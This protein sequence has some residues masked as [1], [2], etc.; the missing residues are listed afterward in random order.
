M[1][2]GH[3]DGEGDAVACGLLCDTCRRC[4]LHKRRV[5]GHGGVTAGGITAC[6]GGR[7]AEVRAEGERRR[8]IV[9]STCGERSGTE[10]VLVAHHPF[11]IDVVGKEGERER[12]KEKEKQ[13]EEVLR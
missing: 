6:H 5:V 7:G 12:E 8:H 10:V 3:L 9:G 1:T 2:V 4:E 13:E 11:Y